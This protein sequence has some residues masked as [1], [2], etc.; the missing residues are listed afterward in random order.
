MQNFESFEYQALA[1]SVVNKLIYLL[2]SLWRCTFSG[3]F[4]GASALFR[5]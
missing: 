4:L 2:F 5:G 3:V 1:I